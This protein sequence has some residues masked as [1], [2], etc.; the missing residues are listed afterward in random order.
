MSLF[1][2]L[3]PEG[4]RQVILTARFD[5]RDHCLFVEDGRLLSSSVKAVGDCLTMAA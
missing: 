4:Q 5:V 1:L 3:A 2:A